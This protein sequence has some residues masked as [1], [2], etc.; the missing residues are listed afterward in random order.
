MKPPGWSDRLATKLVLSYFLVVAVGIGGVIL[1]ARLTGPSLFDRAM[2]HMG[3][4]P[5][6]GP[7]AGAVAGA[8]GMMGAMSD[9]MRQD[10]E[11]AFAD[12]LAQALLA[13]GAAAALATIAVSLFVARRVTAPLAALATGSRGLAQG[14]Y[15]TRVPVTSR[16]ELGELAT[17]FNELAAALESAERRRVHL[18]GDVAHELRTPL[19]TLRGYLEGLIDGVVAP[20]PE[21]W[22]QLHGETN[23]LG[24]LV[25]DLQELSRV[26]SGRAGLTPTPQSPARLVA[27]VVGRLEGAFRDKGVICLADVEPR[28]PDVLAD[29]DRT[30]QVLTNLL[31]NALR[32]TP[33]DGEVRVTAATTADG[34][35]VRFAVRDTGVGIAAE[36]L[37][38]VFDR[39]YRV[40]PARSRAMGGSGVGLTIARALVEAQSGQIRAESAGAGTGA[41]FSFTLPLAPGAHRALVRSSGILTQS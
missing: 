39:F 5:G 32:Y 18:I 7:G 19:T 12:A 10:T 33:P 20:S 11:A 41:T 23:R 34:R 8:G 4:G 2:R 25:A 27:T 22:Q 1:G 14:D 21:L 15:G 36:H 17:T 16:D 35:A 13:G 40:D 24:R 26:E 38:H 3:A 37:P 6:P 31:T 28:L 9:A 30:I 29:E